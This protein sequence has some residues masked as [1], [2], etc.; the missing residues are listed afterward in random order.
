MTDGIAKY[1]YVAG[2]GDGVLRV[3]LR[4]D[5][6]NCAACS[7]G[8]L[9][10]KG[11]IVEVPCPTASMALTGRKVRILY[12]GGGLPQWLAAVAPMALFVGMAVALVLAGVPDLW[13][14]AGAVAALAAWFAFAHIYNRRAA[15]PTGVELVEHFPDE[16]CYSGEKNGGD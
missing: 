15:R 11:K 8:A 6:E 16:G 4:I 14:V 1:G 9:C 7:L 13:C 5:G 3:R 2:A 12:R 10:G